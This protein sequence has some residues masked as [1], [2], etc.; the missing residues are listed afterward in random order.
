M[1]RDVMQTA[2]LEMFA[3]VAI[4]LFF[5]AFAGIVLRTMLRRK[6]ELVEIQN[7]PLFDGNEVERG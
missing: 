2:G 6:D 1:R 5:L 4:V 7:L 3:E